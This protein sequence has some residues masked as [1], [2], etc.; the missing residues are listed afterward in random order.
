MIKKI[1]IAE[2]YESSN[3]SVQKTIEELGINNPDYVYYCDD[4]LRRIE[5]CKQHNDSYDLLITDL[6]FDDDE[7]VQTLKGGM[8]LIAAARKIQPDLKVLVFSAES[9]PI[10]IETLFNTYGIDGY[11]RKA[12][13]DTKEL[14]LAI[15]H[16]A[17]NQSYF[18]RHLVQ[19]IKKKNTHEFTEYDIAIISLLASGMRQKDIPAYLQDHQIRPWG[20]SSVEKRLNLMREVLEMSKNEQLVAYCKDMGII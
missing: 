1:L 6:Y 13:Y 2:D 8:D 16:I 18:P 11:V 4:A 20:L 14:K 10:V 3:L 12:R 7:R 15:S 19:L 17:N 5:K 9:K